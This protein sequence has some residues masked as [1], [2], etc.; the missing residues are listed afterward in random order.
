MKILQALKAYSAVFVITCA[1]FIFNSTEFMPIGILSLIAQD[2]GVSEAAVGLVITFYAWV[3]ALA[4]LP[5]MLLSSKIELKKLML[6]ILALFIL[7]HIISSLANSFGLLIFSRLLV[8]TAH[9]IFWS[10]V[11]V[12]A[13]RSAPKGGEAIALSLVLTGTAV[14]MILGLPLGRVI[15]IYLGWRM[16]FLSIGILGLITWI[17]LYKISPKLPSQSNLS[18]QT[19]PSLLENKIFINLCLLTLFL[20]SAHFTAYSYIEPFLAQS[21]SEASITWILVLFGAMGFWLVFYF[22]NFLLKMLG[23][24]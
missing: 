15:G 24:L 13:V 21:F 12:M 18:L 4:S 19:L 11:S 10:I 6:S 8:A 23:F 16:T 2:F 1:C 5:L 17:L 20:I 9:A 7:A 14:A 22:L 3:V